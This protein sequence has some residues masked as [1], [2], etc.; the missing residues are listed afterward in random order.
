VKKVYGIEITNELEADM[1][2][3][4]LEK[5]GREIRDEGRVITKNPFHHEK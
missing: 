1:F 5:Q 4:W 2:G 3:Q